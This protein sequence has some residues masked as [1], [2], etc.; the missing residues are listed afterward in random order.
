MTPLHPVDV[1]P[2]R[3]P[4]D[5]SPVQAVWPGLAENA[6]EPPFLAGPRSRLS[7]LGRALRI[8]GEFI[9]GFRRL[10][11]LGP[12]VT[13]FGSARFSPTHRYYALARQTG[14]AL[15]R[16]GFAVMTGGGPGIMAAANQGAREV[17]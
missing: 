3:P 15:G 17:A 16:Q 14:A 9:R 13:V 10:H 4:A 5:A 12:A 2:P 7:E 6:P 8:F 1:L 11:F